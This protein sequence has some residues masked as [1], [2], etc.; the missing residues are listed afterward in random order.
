M[1]APLVSVVMPVFNGAA[2]LPEAVDSILGQTYENLE[3]VAIDDGSTDDTPRILA[4][5]ADRRVRVLTQANR[6]VA[7]ALNAGIGASRG[8]LIARMDADDLSEPIRIERQVAYLQTNPRCVVVGTNARVISEE[9]LPLYDSDL[10]CDDAGARQLLAQLRSPFYH[11]SVLM[12]CEALEVAG[13]YDERVGQQVEDLVL[14]SRLAALG[15]LANVP[16]CLYRYRLRPSA[17]SILPRRNAQRRRAVLA[18]IL[19][20]GYA[21]SEDGAELR[22]LSVSVPHRRRVSWYELQVG[23]ALLDHCGDARAA[24]RR[25]DRALRLDPANG[26]VW[27]NLA[28]TLLPSPLR[29]AWVGRRNARLPVRPI[30]GA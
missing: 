25:F 21:T 22:A 8:S 17:V 26:R 4:A 6:G 16:E 29:A 20:T 7:G 30:S 18:R 14:W 11:G 19:R 10:P 12:R 5:V 3:L 23:K 2:Y 28:L 27:F 1:S 13:L 9:D 15:E 24:R